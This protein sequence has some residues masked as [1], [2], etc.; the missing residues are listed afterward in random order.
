MTAVHCLYSVQNWITYSAGYN[1]TLAMIADAA[2]NGPYSLAVHN[3]NR[4]SLP[5]RHCGLR[6]RSF[7]C[8]AVPGP[9]W[10]A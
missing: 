6:G 5:R 2:A 10:H 4:P 9:A 3:G 7:L 1:T 8:S